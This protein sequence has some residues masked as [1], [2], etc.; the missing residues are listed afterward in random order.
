MV[1]G[2]ALIPGLF[3][4]W[5]LKRLCGV[6]K[7][8]HALD[9]S[10]CPIDGSTNQKA[11]REGD[12]VVEAGIEATAEAVPLDEEDEDDDAA[13]A[14]VKMLASVPVSECGE[15]MLRAFRMALLTTAVRSGE[16]CLQGPA[17]KLPSP[18]CHA[19]LACA[20][21]APAGT[22]MLPAVSPRA[23]TIVLEAAS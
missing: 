11:D 13:I 16:S 10:A 19:P 2:G 23:D 7:L 18:R 21:P 1:E 9:F 14:A 4:L 15:M 12:G 3:V 5:P 17:V 20:V 6:P 22:V 8:P